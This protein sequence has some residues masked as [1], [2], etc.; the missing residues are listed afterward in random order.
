MIRLLSVLAFILI[1]AAA[2]AQSNTFPSSG[3][4][5][6][7]TTSPSANIHIYETSQNPEIFLHRDTTIANA[8]AGILG[9]RS[10][11]STTY[12]GEIYFAPKYSKLK[13]SVRF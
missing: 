12:G 8:G 10:A 1:T 7:G 3:D 4:V 13:N 2:H 6:I 9:V 5:G 11:E